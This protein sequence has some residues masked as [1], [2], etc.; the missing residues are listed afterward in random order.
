MVAD[1]CQESCAKWLEILVHK[2]LWLHIEAGLSD[3]LPI[4]LKLEVML[5]KVQG[6][7]LTY[8]EKMCK[9][10]KVS[11]D[12]HLITMTKTGFPQD[13]VICHI[14]CTNMDGSRPAKISPNAQ[15]HV[16]HCAGLQHRSVGT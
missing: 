4:V 2:H 13:S 10:T 5:I 9:L 3:R 8:P 12:N 6:I 7:Q 15:L 16:I 14:H 1:Q 11:N